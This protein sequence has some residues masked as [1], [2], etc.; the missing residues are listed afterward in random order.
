MPRDCKLLA[1]TDFCL[2]R[3]VTMLCGRSWDFGRRLLIC[4]TLTRHCPV[5]ASQ[6]LRKTPLKI[7]RR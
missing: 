5:T 1:T 4:N 2:D 7:Q 3:T 6:A